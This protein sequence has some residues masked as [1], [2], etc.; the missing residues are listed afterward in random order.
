MTDVI[1]NA[2][3]QIQDMLVTCSWR[4]VEHCDASDFQL[5][6]TDLGVCYTFNNPLDS[7]KVL[8][9][10]QAGSGNGLYL[11]LNAEQNEYVSWDNSAAG[12]K[13]QYISYDTNKH[14]VRCL[15]P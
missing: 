5:T 8:H 6:V 9:V 14:Y 15:P 1:L 12:F 10:N 2:T 13:V 11:R 7:N 4:E 3:H